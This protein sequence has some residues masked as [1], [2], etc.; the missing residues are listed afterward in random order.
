MSQE[1]APNP[2]PKRYANYYFT[3]EKKHDNLFLSL[4]NSKF[5]IFYKPVLDPE[6]SAR[7]R[8]VQIMSE[9]YFKN[10]EVGIKMTIANL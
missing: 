4:R 3:L 6:K 9:K 2:P 10:H 8:F 7:P 5:G 1:K